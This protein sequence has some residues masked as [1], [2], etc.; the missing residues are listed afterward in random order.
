[1]NLARTHI[2][3]SFALL[4]LLLTAS[5][6]HAAVLKIATLSPDGTSWMKK[7]RQGA[8]EIA[9]RTSNRVKI[10]YYPG[11]V[12]GDQKAML[13]KMRI[14]QLHGAAVTGGA[15]TNH[16][17]DADIYGLPLLFK[18]HEELMYVRKQMDPLIIQGLEKKGLISFGIAEGGFAY[19]FSNSPIKSISDLHKQ[20]AWI[21]DTDSA[22]DAIKAFDLKPIPLPMSDVLPGLQTSLIDTFATSPIGA[23]ALQWHSQVK[24]LTDMPLLYSSGTLVVSKRAMNKLKKDDQAIVNEVMSRVF[25]EID[26]QNQ[27]DNQAALAALKNQGIKFITPTNENISNWVSTSDKANKLVVKKGSVSKE[28]YDMVIKHTTDFRKKQ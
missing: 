19:I 2:T 16:Y 7:M 6:S 20:K 18:S 28:M 17:K 8:K 21:P 26:L 14:N 10:K 22:R 27:K 24:Y 1:M 13:R 4:S 5:S 3:L 11:G 15:L 25:S 23:I 12:M 9:S